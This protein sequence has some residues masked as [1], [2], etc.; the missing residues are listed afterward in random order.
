VR[1][2]EDGGIVVSCGVVVEVV[3]IV[4]EKYRGKRASAATR[5]MKGSFGVLDDGRVSA[6]EGKRESKRTSSSTE[7]SSEASSPSPSSSALIGFCSSLP[8]LA[9][10]S[11]SAATTPATAT[12]AASGTSSLCAGAS[13]GEGD[14][15]L[16]LSLRT[17]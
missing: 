11:S 8:P 4:V 13:A 10:P 6:V 9:T 2:D 17:P 15:A 1:G 5:A 14:R 7:E 3:L 16:F 12:K